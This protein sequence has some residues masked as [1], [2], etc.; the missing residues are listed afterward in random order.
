MKGEAR[1]RIYSHNELTREGE[2]DGDSP[3]WEEGCVVLRRALLVELGREEEHD[4]EEDD[5]E[6]DDE[7][8]DD[9]EA[10]EEEDEEGEDE[11]DEE[12]EG[13]EIEGE[14]EREGSEVF[15]MSSG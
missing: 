14:G 8:D 12:Q 7:E 10:E 9:D 4:D 13:K 3:C 6:E 15:D 11:E 1:D 5:D 2:E